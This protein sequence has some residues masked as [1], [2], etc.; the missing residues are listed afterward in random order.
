VLLSDAIDRVRRKLDDT[1]TNSPYNSDVDIAKNID[2]W[3]RALT[4]QHAQADPSWYNSIVEIGSSDAEQVSNGVYRYR[5]PEYTLRINNLHE[6][7]ATT[8]NRGK[9][10]LPGGFFAGISSDR[11]SLIDQRTVD[12]RLNEATDLSFWVTKTPANLHKGTVTKAGSGSTF[13]MAGAAGVGSYSLENPTDKYVNAIIEITGVAVP[14]TPRDPVGQ[15]RRVTASSRSLDGTTEY[16]VECTMSTAWT[17][18]PA[19]SDTYEMHLEIDEAYAPYI[20]LLAAESI[21]HRTNNME[22]VRSLRRQIEELKAKHI[23]GIQPRQVQYPHQIEVQSAFGNR[24]DPDKDPT[25][26]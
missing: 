22:G 10:I 20:V 25:I 7:K 6:T 2:D 9:S 24:S 1:S 4:M 13:Y 8:E 18:A 11:W 23:E 15:V 5:L 21:F 26:W 17:T 19:V 3:I 14:A 12:V 16:V